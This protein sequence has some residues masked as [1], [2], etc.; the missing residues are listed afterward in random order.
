VDHDELRA[1]AAGTPP[2]PARIVLLEAAC[3]TEGLDA[4]AAALAEAHDGGCRATLR[5]CGLTAHTDTAA[6]LDALG[7]RLEREG[8]KLGPH[9]LAMPAAL[10]RPEEAALGALG[11]C[12]GTPA[13]YLLLPAPALEAIQRRGTLSA[14]ADGEMDARHWWGGLLGL[15]ASARSVSLVPEAPGPGLSTL[16]PAYR[17]LGPSPGAGEL[18]PA[19]PSRLRLKLDFSALISATGDRPRAL[20]RLAGRIVFAA[21]EML[22]QMLGSNGPRRLALELGGIAR[23]V[24]ARG[25]DPRSFGALQWVKSRIWTFRDGARAASVQL[26]RTRGAGGG[27]KPFPLPDTLEVADADVLDRAMLIHGARHSHL[28]CLSPWSLA[29]PAS[30]RDCLNLLP[31]LACAD[32]IAWRRPETEC[33]PAFYCEALR[34]AWAVALR[35]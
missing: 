27:L 7:Q 29:P 2:A 22:G 16:A 13:I 26:A 23:A 33:P 31:A 17:W 4:P 5:L 9:A 32:S 28:V 14:G 25:F 30:G 24:I 11:A 21:D 12:S 15:A 19:A 3:E 20:G 1:L 6:L 10:A 8:R 18:I 35:S 34:F